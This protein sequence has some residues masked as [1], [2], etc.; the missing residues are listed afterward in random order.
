MPSGVDLLLLFM[1]NGLLGALLVSP[2]VQN[3]PQVCFPA[4]FSENFPRTGPLIISISSRISSTS[5]DSCRGRLAEAC[6]LSP[7][8]TPRLL[9]PYSH[10]VFTPLICSH[11]SRVFPHPLCLRNPQALPR[12]LRGSNTLSTRRLIFLQICGC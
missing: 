9:G 6:D 12:L 10:R 7:L 4:Q 1:D 8:F 5:S 2:L 3:V 11:N